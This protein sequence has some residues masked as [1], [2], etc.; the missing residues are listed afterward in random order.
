[1][2]L[3]LNWLIIPMARPYWR[4]NKEVVSNILASTI[5]TLPRKLDMS[6]LSGQAMVMSL[7]YLVIPL[8]QSISYG[9]RDQSSSSQFLPSA[10]TTSPSIP[11]VRAMYPVK[12]IILL[13]V[14]LSVSFLPI[15]Q[16][17]GILINGLGIPLI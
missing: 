4:L 12:E 2:Q 14:I 13:T 10:N 11:T 16:L 9:W 8:N 6:L 5:L 15:L 17:G 3:R 1:M 7:N